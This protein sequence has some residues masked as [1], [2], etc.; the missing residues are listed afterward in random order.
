MAGTSEDEVEDLEW[1]GPTDEHVDGDGDGAPSEAGAEGESAA[2]RDA[3]ATGLVTDHPIEVDVQR[4]V[5]A[6]FRQADLDESVAA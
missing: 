6:C 4:E 3:V 1:S 2:H 5:E